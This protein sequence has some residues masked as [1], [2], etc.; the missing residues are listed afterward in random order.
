MTHWFFDLCTLES[1]TE[2]FRTGDATL[3]STT[4]R[5][6]GVLSKVPLVAAIMGRTDGVRKLISAQF[7]TNERGDVLANR[8]DTRE[9]PQTT[10]AQRLG[11]AADALRTALCHDLPAG[12]GEL[13]VIRVFPAWPK[14]WDAEFTLL[15]GGFLVTSAMRRG[16]IEFLEVQSKFGGECRLRNPWNK[17]EVM[18]HRNGKPAEKLM[19]DASG[20]LRFNTRPGENI[21]C[22]RPG[23]TPQKFRR[24]IEPAKE[25]SKQQPIR[26]S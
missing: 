3:G 19:P 22:L 21:I 10:S 24:T 8:M 15:R 26:E 12:P 7:N 5:R 17:T 13:P 11:N 23:D 1:D 6:V 2:K 16:E 9:G 25:S 4:G 20:L 14:E 18:L